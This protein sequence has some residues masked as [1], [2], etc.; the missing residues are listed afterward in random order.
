MEGKLGR[1]GLRAEYRRRVF[2][3]FNGDEWMCSY[4][5][6]YFMQPEASSPTRDYT[7]KD[8]ISDLLRDFDDP[9]GTDARD[10]AVWRDGRILAVI[11]KGRDGRPELI[12][13]T[14]GA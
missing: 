5:D 8:V 2:Q 13:F 12:D 3:V 10:M 9:D 1:A 11:R 6:M 14:G 7:L 4:G